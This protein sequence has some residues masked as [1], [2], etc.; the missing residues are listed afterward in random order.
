MTPGI[1]AQCGYCGSFAASPGVHTVLEVTAPPAAAVA[2]LV[3]RGYQFFTEEGQHWFVSP[4]G[5]VSNVTR[6]TAGAAQFDA[7]ADAADVAP[8]SKGLSLVQ[9]AR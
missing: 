1:G 5:E 9:D 8:A 4:A 2:A 6:W 3:A 7:L